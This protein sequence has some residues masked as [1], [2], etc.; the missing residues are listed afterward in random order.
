MHWYLWDPH[1]ALALAA[2]LV[3]SPFVITFGLMGWRGDY[4]PTSSGASICLVATWVV[5]VLVVLLAFGIK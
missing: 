5:G 4:H 1:P 2:I 3:A